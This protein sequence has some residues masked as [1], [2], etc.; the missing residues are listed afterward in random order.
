MR[1]FLHLWRQRSLTFNVTEEETGDGTT[2][3]CL[4]MVGNDQWRWTGTVEQASS[5][6]GKARFDDLQANGAQAGLKERFWQWKPTARTGTPTGSQE[7]F[8]SLEIAKQVRS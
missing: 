3:V 4:T 2:L 6:F 1:G 8:T 5:L 7:L